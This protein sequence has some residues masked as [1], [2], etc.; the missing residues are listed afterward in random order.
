MSDFLNVLS[1]VSGGGIT[2]TYTQHV[3][4]CLKPQYT[5]Y[6]RSA[7]WSTISSYYYFILYWDN[8]SVN[9]HLLDLVSKKQV[10]F[11]MYFIHESPCNKYW[12]ILGLEDGG[13]VTYLGILLHMP[14]CHTLYKVH[15]DMLSWVK[16]FF[17]LKKV[18]M[19]IFKR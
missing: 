6:Y 9:V 10:I 19:Y 1:L 3:P 17:S 13:Y 15:V 7:I 14:S 18:C 12:G 11:K 16:S 8:V 2:V 4:S 5:I